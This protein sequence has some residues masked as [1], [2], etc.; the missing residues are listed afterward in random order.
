M[1]FSLKLR[2]P[3]APAAEGAAVAPV[4]TAFADAALP[5]RECDAG[6]VY[7]APEVVLPAGEEDVRTA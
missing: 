2:P 4:A 7:E 5:D 3:P 6:V 1:V